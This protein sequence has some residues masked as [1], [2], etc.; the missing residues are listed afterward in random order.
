MEYV[1]ASEVHLGIPVEDY[2]GSIDWY[3][4]SFGLQT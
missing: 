2:E 4:K 1:R 3:I